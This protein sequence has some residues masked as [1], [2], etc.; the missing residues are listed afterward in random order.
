MVEGV[1]WEVHVDGLARVRVSSAMQAGPLAV[2]SST[3][4]NGPHGR[5]VRGRLLSRSSIRFRHALCL[6]VQGETI[7]GAG[8]LRQ[9]ARAR[10]PAWPVTPGSGS[11]GPDAAVTSAGAD[12]VSTIAALP[13]TATVQ[14]G[15]CRT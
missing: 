12:P 9:A 14:N 15:H 13:E 3:G 8:S 11:P 4:V 5:S 2:R 6:G 1:P 7:R 10:R